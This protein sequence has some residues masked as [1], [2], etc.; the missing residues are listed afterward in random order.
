MRKLNKREKIMLGVFLIFLV[1][2]LGTEYLLFPSLDK[3]TMLKS[4]RAELQQQWAEIN[5]Y[6]GSEEDIK[7]RIEKLTKETKAI[8]EQLPSAESTHLYWEYINDSAK[9]SGVTVNQIQE[10]DMDKE[11]NHHPISVVITGTFSEVTGFLEKLDSMPYLHATSEVSFQSSEQGV[12]ATLTL[13]ISD[14]QGG[15]TIQ[16]GEEESEQKGQQ[17][18]NPFE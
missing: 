3:I 8:T 6:V 7:G 1:A 10:D 9:Q 2:A 4:E 17:V 15:S 14:Y 12:T 5:F 16:K 13:F 18:R 11:T